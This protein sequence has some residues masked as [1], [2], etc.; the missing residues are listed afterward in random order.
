M[1]CQTTNCN[2]P[3]QHWVAKG[4][5]AKRVCTDCSDHLTALSGWVYM[6]IRPKS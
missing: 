1:K 2:Q 3:S 5:I 6:T 4:G